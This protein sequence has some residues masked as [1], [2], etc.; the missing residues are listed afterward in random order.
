MLRRQ[1]AILKD[2]KGPKVG[3]MRLDSQ[4][5]SWS[6]CSKKPEV[7]RWLMAIKWSSR[8]KTRNSLDSCSE[9]HRRK[10]RVNASGRLREQLQWSKALH[11]SGKRPVSGVQATWLRY[12]SMA[13]NFIRH[14]SHIWCHWK[15]I[16]VSSAKLNMSKLNR[17][18]KLASWKI[19]GT[20]FDIR[21]P[22][23]FDYSIVSWTHW[24]QSHS[25]CMLIYIYM[26]DC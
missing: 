1:A 12:V 26:D 15:C 19:I 14:V 24:P 4:S 20:Y 21:I 7:C 2:K 6:K 5:S 25:L 8:T 18:S 10:T 11:L 17:E 9:C 22:A 16:A 23:W 3:I 13:A